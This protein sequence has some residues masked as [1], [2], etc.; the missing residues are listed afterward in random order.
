MIYKIGSLK[1]TP[2][3]YKAA[4][5]PGHTLVVA[6]PGTGKTR[7]LLARALYLLEQ[8]IPPEKIIILTFTVKTAQELRQRLQELGA[9]ARVDTFHALAYDLCRSQGLK[10]KLLEEREKTALLAQIL[11]YLGQNPRQAS[12]IA[13]RV[14]FSPPLEGTQKIYSLYRDTLKSEGLWDYERLLEEGKNHPLTQQDLHLL[15]DEF[16]DLNRGLIQFLVSF[17]KATYFLVGDPAQAIYGFRGGDPYLVRTFIAPL[18]G[19]KIFSLSESFRLPEEVLKRSETLRQRLYGERPLFTKIKGGK[20]AGFACAHKDAEAQKIVELVEEKLG[21][22]QMERARGDTQSPSD[23]AVLFRVRALMTPVAEKLQQRGIPLKIPGQKVSSL[24]E[25]LTQWAKGLKTIPT[26]GSLAQELAVFPASLRNLIKGIVQSC[27]DLEHLQFTLSLINDLDLL[28]LT[29]DAVS[30]LTIH[31]AKGLEFP[32]VI[33]AGAEEGLL[34]FNLMPEVNEDEE[35]RLAYV[36]IT[37]ASKAFYFTW[38]QKRFVY[39]QKLPGEI[40]RFFKSFPQKPLVPKKPRKRQMSL[41]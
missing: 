40:S 11:K 1:L 30:L 38:A 17:P 3:Q 4:T 29:H 27:T 5:N 24:A 41:F 25:H 39:G 16:Q 2:E 10:I 13:E 31:E 14:S 34:P 26:E 33:L 18:P 6:G 22:F 19:I 12:K 32:V 8:D 28:D 35:K 15:I 20:V 37:R 23:L 36:G 9:Q 21:T 7:T